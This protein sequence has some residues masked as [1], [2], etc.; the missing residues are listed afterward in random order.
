MIC[1]KCGKDLPVTEFH[2]DKQRKT[3]YRGSCKSCR[4]VYAKDKP[5]RTK[6]HYKCVRCGKLK[7]KAEF[8]DTT[9]E[10]GV[11]LIC[12][13]CRPLYRVRGLPS[14]KPRQRRV[15]GDYRESKRSALLREKIKGQFLF[16]M[17]NKCVDCGLEVG[18]ENPPLCF[19]FHHIGKKDFN[20][21]GMLLAASRSDKDY[22]IV[23]KELEKC[24]VVCAICHRKRHSV[25]H[26][27]RR[28]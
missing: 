10:S 23:K 3:G 28:K 16:E 25:L 24:V 26:K 27:K 18:K 17:G 11:S 13:D 4:R 2:V 14:D 8:V 20:I 22:D 9:L 5:W 12:E 7:P 19:D 1:N 15:R 21:G 6:T